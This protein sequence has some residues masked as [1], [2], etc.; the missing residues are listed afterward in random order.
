MNKDEIK[1]N[2]EKSASPEVVGRLA[3]AM[4]N[5]GKKIADLHALLK[6]SAKDFKSAVLNLERADKQMQDR[7]DTHD[8]YF[9]NLE[10]QFQDSHTHLQQELMRLYTKQTKEL[11]DTLRKEYK[12]KIKELEE[13]IRDIEYDR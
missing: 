5:V 10:K 3:G 12:A 6:N 4:A 2:L 13:R 11:E 9:K 7:L 8:A 1:K